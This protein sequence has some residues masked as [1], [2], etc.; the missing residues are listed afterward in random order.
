[1]IRFLLV[2]L[3]L[4]SLSTMPHAVSAQGMALPMAA[5]QSGGLTQGQTLQGKAMQGHDMQG[6]NMPGSGAGSAEAGNCRPGEGHAGSGCCQHSLACA[7]MCAGLSA[8]AVPDGPAITRGF[9]RPAYPH[10]SGP[11]LAGLPP[12]LNERPPDRHPV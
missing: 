2:A 9:L 7:W 4:L 5:S 8:L 10:N 6:H 12:P 11:V 1:M 3:T